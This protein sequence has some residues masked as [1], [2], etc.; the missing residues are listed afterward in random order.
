MDGVTNLGFQFE[1][2]LDLLPNLKTNWNN[3]LVGKDELG[4]RFVEEEG[5]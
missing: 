3:F 5:E 4:T 2:L 1:D